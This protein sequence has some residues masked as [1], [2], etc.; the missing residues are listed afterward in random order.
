[1]V[2]SMYEQNLLDQIHGDIKHRLPEA[3]EK[4][5]NSI[6]HFS[7]N[8][9]VINDYV[10][11]EAMKLDRELPPEKRVFNVEEEQKFLQKVKDNYLKK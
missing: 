9:N 2:L 3:M 8:M 4:F 10:I 6:Q 7:M 1:M 11:I 5:E